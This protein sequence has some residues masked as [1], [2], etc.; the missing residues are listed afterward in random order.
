MLARIKFLRINSSTILALVDRRSLNNNFPIEQPIH[1]LQRL[2]LRLRV[3]QCNNR[4]ADEIESH[5]D[6]VGLTPNPVNPNR[7]H[8]SNN[9]GANSPTGGS[10]VE[11][12]SA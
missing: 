5:E 9:D 10:K 7:P 6:E 1:I 4:N 3:K 8:L 2:P 11:T 12:A